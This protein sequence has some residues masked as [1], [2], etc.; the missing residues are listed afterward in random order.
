[1]TKPSAKG[2]AFLQHL[3]CMTEGERIRMNE[4]IM[5]GKADTQQQAAE[6]VIGERLGAQE[7]VEGQPASVATLYGYTHTEWAIV[8]WLLV[9]VLLLTHIYR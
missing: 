9:I 7:L 1:M 6:M 8:G 3:A 4:L 5:S 2:E